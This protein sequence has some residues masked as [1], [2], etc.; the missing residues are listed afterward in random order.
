MR[1]VL[2][3]V[4]MFAMAGSAQAQQ[5]AQPAAPGDAV[6]VEARLAPA[7]TVQDVQK[8]SSDVKPIQSAGRTGVDEASNS[9]VAEEAVVRQDP[10][11]RSWWWLVGAIVVGGIILAAL[12]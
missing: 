9:V 4:L 12:L 6:T 3:L 7:P 11:T 1:A 5:L 10:T 8:V 2:P